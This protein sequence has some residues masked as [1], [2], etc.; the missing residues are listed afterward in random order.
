[1]ISA[2]QR[3]WRRSGIGG[4]DAAAVCGQHPTRTAFGVW[5]EKLFPQAE[6]TPTERMEWG[7]KL[8]SLIVAETFDRVK[9]RYPGAV[10]RVP[11]KNSRPITNSQHPFM[12]ANIDGHAMTE[13]APRRT[14][15]P[16]ISTK[17]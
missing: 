2:R 11:R 12:L 17:F 15:S 16:P 13:G 4:S 1:M 6:D 3:E 10:L 7:N 8:E 5:E 9:G 14:V